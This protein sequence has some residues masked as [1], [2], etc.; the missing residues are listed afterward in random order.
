MWKCDECDKCQ[1]IEWK[2]G[3]QL[4]GIIATAGCLVIDKRKD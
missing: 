2:D 1:G 4:G 3:V